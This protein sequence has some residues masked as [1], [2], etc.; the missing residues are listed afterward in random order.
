MTIKKQHSSFA[1]AISPEFDDDGNWTGAVTAILEE[2]VHDDLD[3]EDL[4]QIRSVCGML[5]ACLPLMEEDPDFL[6]YIKGY[7]SSNYTQL[8][9]EILDEAETE[10]KPTFIRSKDGNVITLDFNTKTHGSA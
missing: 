4:T 6:D 10:S 1:V 8:I 3:S 2:D 9:D 5:A 7:F